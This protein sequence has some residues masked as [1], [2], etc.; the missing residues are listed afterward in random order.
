MIFILLTSKAASKAQDAAATTHSNCCRWKN[1]SGEVYCDDKPRHSSH[2]SYTSEGSE[3][4]IKAHDV[5]IHSVE[6]TPGLRLPTSV[7]RAVSK[8]GWVDWQF[9]PNKHN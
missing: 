7:L 5:V 6:L 1:K 9:E 8:S 4:R 3:T 2:T